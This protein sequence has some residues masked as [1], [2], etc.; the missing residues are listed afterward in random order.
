MTRLCSIDGCGKKHYGRGLCAAHWMRQRRTGSTRNTK[1]VRIIAPKGTGHITTQGYRYIY[2]DGVKLFEHV[3]IVERLLGRPLKDNEDVHH[4]NE[5]RS[6]NRHS[7]LVVCPDKKYHQLLHTRMRA[8][9]ASGHADWLPCNICKQY[10][11]P[12]HLRFPISNASRYHLECESRY[13]KDLR[14]R[15]HSVAKL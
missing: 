6:D 12:S 8:L 5:C 10:A 2:V 9:A 15:K 4:V 3:A 13:R 7:N 1:P 11:D 14:A